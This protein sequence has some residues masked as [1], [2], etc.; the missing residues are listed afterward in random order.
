MVSSER[1]L[2]PQVE[3]RLKQLAAKIKVRTVYEHIWDRFLTE[4]ARRYVQ[5]HPS[6]SNDLIGIWATVFQVS[7]PRA[8]VEIAKRCNLLFPEEDGVLLAAIGGGSD[9]AQSLRLPHPRLEA[10]GRLFVG[11]QVARKIRLRGQ[12]TKVERLIR[13]FEHA[14]WRRKIDNP[15][16]DEPDPQYVHAAVKVANKNLLHIRFEVHGGGRSV[17]WVHR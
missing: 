1:L 14:K 6:I 2:P 10:D 13:A 7:R 8:V 5:L 3:S 12:A 15:F 16:T 11:E 9:K 17:V 4:E